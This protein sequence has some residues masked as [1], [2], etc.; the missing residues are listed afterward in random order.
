MAKHSADT[1][2]TPTGPVSRGFRRRWWGLIPGVISGALTAVHPS[3][4]AGLVAA[5]AFLW[6]A[7]FHVS[8][9]AGTLLV[10]RPMLDFATRLGIPVGSVRLNLAAVIGLAA[11]G[12]AVLYGVDRRVRRRAIS[13][14]GVPAAALGMLVLL[15]A[16]GTLNGMRVLGPKMLAIGLRET[17]RLGSLLAFY[18]LTVNLLRDGMGAHRLLRTLYAALA[19]PLVVGSAQFLRFLL[20][21][22]Y[23]GPLTALPP[24]RLT[25]TFIHGVAFGVFLAL[26]MVISLTLWSSRRRW[27]IPRGLVLLAL[28]V[29]GVLLVFTWARGAWLFF[30]V[31]LLAKLLLEPRR[32]ILPVLVVGCLGALFFGD[33][34]AARFSDVRTD[35]SLRRIVA[36]NQHQNSFEWRIYNWFVLVNI[37]LRHPVLG[38]GTGAT[39]EVNPV[40]AVN[41]ELQESRGYSAHNE[42]VAF[43]VEYGAAGVLVLALY[44][45]LLLRWLWRRR[46]RMRLAGQPAA[47]FA[48]AGLEILLGFLVISVFT[49]SPLSS[50][51]SYY[52]VTCLLAL[53]Q[54]GPGEAP[55]PS[56]PAA[57]SATP[58][59]A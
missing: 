59:R 46:R 21:G 42:F 18:W 49:A 11:V 55:E 2:R 54:V 58:R 38:H 50:T 35:L 39:N 26:F 31:A 12:T 57:G 4:G 6:L 34:I 14:G 32:M 36:W 56:P 19:V 40:L 25:G 22:N 20:E 29:S 52:V 1:V 15:A 8:W 37:G 17:I 24:G 10:I 30:G 48:G 33:R 16:C 13:W 5:A 28:G 43:F 44:F 3:L 7:V 23:S 27:G 47:E 51:A 45:G 53:V 9:A 41:R